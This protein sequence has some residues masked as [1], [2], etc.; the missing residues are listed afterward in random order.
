MQLLE[1]LDRFAAACEKLL[2]VLLFAVLVAVVGG[3]IATRNISGIA[4]QQFLE[5]TPV[6]VLWLSLL[7]S[8]LALRR[9]Q[10]IRLELVLRFCPPPVQK[11]AEL[12]TGMFGAA[13]MGILFV[14]SIEF[15]AGEIAIFGSKGWLAVIFPLFFSLACFRC[16]KGCAEAIF[17]PPRK[18]LRPMPD[19]VVIRGKA[20]TP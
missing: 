7:G 13:V 6:M 17:L 1:K 19:A 5:L 8:T 2:I 3:N 11:I 4:F 16:L 12:I 20:E 10:H 14:S 15:V 9:R 18:P